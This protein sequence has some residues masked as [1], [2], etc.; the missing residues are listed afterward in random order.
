MKQNVGSGPL[1][2][3]TD[4]R[5]VNKKPRRRYYPWLDHSMEKGGMQEAHLQFIPN[6][7]PSRSTVGYNSIRT[8]DNSEGIEGI[9]RPPADACP[10]SKKLFT[11]GNWMSLRVYPFRHVEQSM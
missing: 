5:T 7:L 9:D 11:I 3:N 4:H 1:V 8:V 6:I 10:S 2:V